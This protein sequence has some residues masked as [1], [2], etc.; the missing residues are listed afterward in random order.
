MG[1]VFLREPNP[2]VSL[3]RRGGRVALLAGGASVD[4][5][6]TVLTVEQLR[7]YPMLYV[8]DDP[9]SLELFANFFGGVFTVRL[10]ANAEEALAALDREDIAIVVTDHRMPGISGV[11]LCGL[12]RER[13]PAVLRAVLTAHGDQSTA[14]DAINRG[15]VHRFFTKPWN[16]ADVQ[17]VLTDLVVR[18]HLDHTVRTLRRAM[19]ERERDGALAQTRALILHDLSNM[20]V[21][22]S[23]GLEL[24]RR[25]AQALAHVGDGQAV[26]ALLEEV[27]ML[28][29]AVGHLVE[30][31]QRGR[32]VAPSARAEAPNTPIIDVARLVTELVSR[33]QRAARIE[34]HCP[35]D[36]NVRADRVNVV[37]I[38]M[39]LVRNACEAGDHDASGDEWGL[40]VMGGPRR[41]VAEVRVG[42][43]VASGGQ[44]EVMVDDTGPGVPAELRDRIFDLRVSS[45][46]DEGRG[47]GLYVA[48]RL[49][50]AEGGTLELGEHPAGVGARF[51]LTLPGGQ[52]ASTRAVRDSRYASA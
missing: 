39:N 46:A 16:W 29:E 14:I 21:P 15:G 18:A 5:P 11:E 34:M 44:V 49:A 47:L 48:R 32:Y 42:A 10:A 33:D 24:V 26:R 22:L 40:V 12:V 38:L 17:P 27:D 13:H 9:T 31:H 52:T 8:D 51:V 37:R 35:R 43:R 45:R 3:V 25:R 30:I 6:L 28:D 23:A 7:D 50:E 41:A 2:D 36:L 4:E 19:L 1:V 20:T